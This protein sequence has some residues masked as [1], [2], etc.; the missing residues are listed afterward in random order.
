MTLIY[1]VAL[2]P[3]WKRVVRP[4]LVWGTG[5][6]AVTEVCMALLRYSYLSLV[7]VPSSNMRK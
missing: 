1:I 7:A 2:D 5:E 4:N 3:S 6:E